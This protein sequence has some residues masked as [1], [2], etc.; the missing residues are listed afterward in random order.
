[1][2]LPA[3]LSLLVGMVLAQRFKVL[4]LVPAISLTL[5]LMGGAVMVNPTGTSIA[6][7][8]ATVVIVG[9]QI[10]YVLGIAIRHL[11]VVARANRRRAS[12]LANSLTPQRPAH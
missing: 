12:G 9:L 3:I 10:G 5:V 2:L 7:L 1:M 8:T 6:A 4:I 11:M